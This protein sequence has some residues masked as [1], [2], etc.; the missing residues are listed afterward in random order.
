[1]AARF[2][3]GELPRE[4]SPTPKL[5][6]RTQSLISQYSQN[7]PPKSVRSA[8]SVSTLTP[9][10]QRIPSSSSLSQRNI[11]QLSGTASFSHE[12]VGSLPKLRT[13]VSEGVALRANALLEAEKQ[14]QGTLQGRQQVMTLRPPVPSIISDADTF[15]E[16]TLR[17]PPSLGTMIPHPEQPPIAHHLN[18]VRPP[19]STSNVRPGFNPDFLVPSSTPT[20]RPSSTTLLH[21]QIRT[22]QRQLDYKIEEVSQLRRQLEAQA[23]TDVGTLSQQLREAR[24]EAR[25]WKERAEAAKRRVKVFERFTARLRGIREAAVLAD[26]QGGKLDQGSELTSHD[27]VNEDK[28]VGQGNTG[29]DQPAKTQGIRRLVGRSTEGDKSDDSGRTEDAGVVQARI[30]RCLHGGTGQTDGPADSPSLMLS[31]FIDADGHDDQDERPTKDIKQTAF[32]SWMA[33]QEL[34]YLEDVN[35]YPL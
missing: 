2:E 31:D 9:S 24:R 17:D 21:A 13:S 14:H 28:D 3:T 26:R 29:R 12:N 1:M 33:E 22:L 19:S 34:L 35:N 16:P 6:S 27:R 8:K 18:L 4:S 32:G 7:S 15:K 25:M 30:R 20:P 5:G 23:G 10:A 11:R